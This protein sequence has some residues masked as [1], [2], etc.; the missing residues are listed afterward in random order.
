MFERIRP[1]YQCL[2]AK[3][4]NFNVNKTKARIEMFERMGPEYQCLKGMDWNS[5]L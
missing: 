5:N 2:K 1:E 4:R 3:G